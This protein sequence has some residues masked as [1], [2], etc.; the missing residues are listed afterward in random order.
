MYNPSGK[1]GIASW[2]NMTIYSG[3]NYSYFPHEL[4]HLYTYHKVPKDPHLWIGEGIAI[5]Y[6]GTSTYSFHDHM[7]KLKAFLDKYPEYDLSD[8]S[9]LKKTIPNGEHASDFRYVIGGLLMMKIYKKEGVIRLIEVLQY[10][11]TD[12]DFYQ[13]IEDTL[14]V[15]KDKFDTYIKLEMKNYSE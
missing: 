1:G 10:G 12:S 11:T 14:D 6:A 2:R 8:I 15:S 4:V 7:L 5:Y 13:L 3:N 9:K